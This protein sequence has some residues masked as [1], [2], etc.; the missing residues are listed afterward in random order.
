VVSLSSNTASSNG[1]AGV[2]VGGHSL[3]TGN[4]ANDN[5]DGCISSCAGASGIE[6]ADFGTVTSNIANGNAGEGIEVEGIK[7]IVSSNTTNDNGDIGVRVECPGTVTNNKSAGK[8]VENYELEG[9]GCFQ[10]NNT[11]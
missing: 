11:S 6:T 8:G 5:G 1:F 2:L 10:K 4:T 3:I 7:R 9:T